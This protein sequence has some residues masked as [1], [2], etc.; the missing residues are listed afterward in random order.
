MKKIAL[1]LALVMTLSVAA[2]ASAAEVKVGG[3][4]YY[5]ADITSDS[6]TPS[7]DFKLS[8][9]ATV[10]D[11][12]KAAIRFRP[13][14]EDDVDGDGKIDKLDRFDQAYV[15]ISKFG[16]PLS[17]TVGLNS[18]VNDPFSTD[19]F[20]FFS[21]FQGVNIK[22]DSFNGFTGQILLKDS[23]LGDLN[24]DV[25]LSSV[26]QGLLANYSASFGSFGLVA[27]P[28]EDKFDFAVNASVP[29]PSTPVT[30]LL[31]VVKYGDVD[32]KIDYKAGVSAEVGGISL[33]ANYFTDVADKVDKDGK[34]DD[35]K[36]TAGISKDINGAT[37]ALDLTNA[38]DSTTFTA[39]VTVSF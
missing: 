29:I 33:Y 17:V 20:G 27:K 6:I 21:G 4:V 14:A 8:A 19:G 34:V 18:V 22:T 30:G 23:G 31:E 24:N 35:A 32:D 12:V 11:Q 25:K 28:N 36:I 7:L 9:T 15:T 16:L 5:G 38:D 39:S 37:Y 26:V 2:V 13:F 1:L 10:S 3:E